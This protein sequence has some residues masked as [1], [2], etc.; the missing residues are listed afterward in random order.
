MLPDPWE[1]RLLVYGAGFR[2]QGLTHLRTLYAGR[3]LCTLWKR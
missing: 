1:G 2:P 3:T